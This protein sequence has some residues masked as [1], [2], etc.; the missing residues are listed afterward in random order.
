MS[1]RSIMSLVTT[2]LLIV[3]AITAPGQAA[4]LPEGAGKQLV[5]V[6]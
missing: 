4:E 3:I 6:P 2:F 5:G 1:R